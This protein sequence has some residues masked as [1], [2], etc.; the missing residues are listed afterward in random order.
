MASSKGVLAIYS[1]LDTVCE[2]IEKV[3]GRNDFRE[4]EVFTPTSYHEIEHA[5]GFGPSP[6]RWF[7]LFGAMTGTVTGFAMPLLMDWDWPV[8]VGG[9]M[10]GIY[11]LP[12]YV[13]IG[14]EFTILFGAIA[15]VLGVLTMC[16]MPNPKIKVLD[17]RL[18]DDKFGIFVPNVG[19]DS[20]Q[21][22]FLQELGATEVKATT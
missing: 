16:R 3:K 12:A 17:R 20:A 18:T 11:S 15:T 14:F 5:C 13:V 22:K 21:A 6:V 2:A 8:V 9:K 7:T 19:L 4:H 10:P 1:H